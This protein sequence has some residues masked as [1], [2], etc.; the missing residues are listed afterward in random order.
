M[1]GATQQGKSYASLGNTSLPGYATSFS[2]TRGVGPSVFCPV[3]FVQ[4]E[5]KLSVHLI[6]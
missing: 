3:L 6:Y 1:E 4:F 2:S 5:A